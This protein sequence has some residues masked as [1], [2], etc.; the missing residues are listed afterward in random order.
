MRYLLLLSCF[1]YTRQIL[2]ILMNHLI[3]FSDSLTLIFLMF[4]GEF[5]GGLSVVSY[6]Y[7]Y[8][9]KRKILSEN[10]YGI[11]IIH[12]KAQ[13]KKADKLYKIILL[14]FFASSFDFIEFSIVYSIPNKSIIS[15]T[16]DQRLYIIMTIASSLLCTFALR[17]KMGRHHNLSLIGMGICSFIIFIIEL[18]YKSIGKDFSRFILV[19]FLKFSRL[20]FVSFTDVTEKYLVE[21]NF[22]DKFKVIGTEGF[23]GI[24]LCLI[25][26]LIIN[27]NP[28]NQINENYKEF[29]IGKKILMVLFLILFFILSAGLNLY[30]IIC[31]A[32]YNPM[33][34]TLPAYFLNPIF[35]IYYFIFENDFTSGGEKNYFYFII[36]IILSIIIDFLAFIYNEFLILNCFGL[37]DDT[38]YGISN[39]AINNT[40]IVLEEEEIEGDNSFED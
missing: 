28:I 17:L 13:M 31:N 35:I 38:H 23:F 34:K 9:K 12:G 19:Y 16:A 36:N 22:A 37:K 33:A 21:Y 2:G 25:Y 6:H 24:I 26:S 7:F 11:K 29:D 39:R 5:L 27:K 20:I 10:F 18:I 3:N 1:H 14:I 8:F 15:P 4:F 40:L 30:K 32:I